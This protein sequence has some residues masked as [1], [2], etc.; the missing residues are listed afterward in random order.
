MARIRIIHWAIVLFILAAGAN[1]QTPASLSST[2]PAPASAP[3]GNADS[4]GGTVAAQPPP[5]AV[6]PSC[7]EPANAATTS[8]PPISVTVNPATIWQP[9]GGEVIVAVV[10]DAALLKG[11]TARAC[12]G[13]SAAGAD[14]FF[15]PENLAHFG[16]AFIRIRP[17]DTLGLVNLGIVVPDLPEA[18]S[19]VITRWLAGA[20]STGLGVVPVADMRLIGY[21]DAGVLFDVV[22]PVGVTS[23][24]FSLL[25]VAISI[26][27]A[28]LVLHQLSADGMSTRSFIPGEKAIPKVLRLAAR[29]MTF[30]WVLHLIQDGN[31][32]AS[33]SAF[34]ILLWS[35]LV[36][37]SAIYVMALSGSLINIT[38]GT[39]ILLGIAGAAGLI[40][41]GAGRS[42]PTDTQRPPGAQRQTD[43]QRPP[44]TQRITDSAQAAQ[45]PVRPSSDRRDAGPRWADL[46]RDDDDM[47][48]V[49]R[50]QMLF[51]TVVSA[52][53]VALQ[54]LNNYV[55]PDIPSGYQVLMGISNGIYVGKKFT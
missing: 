27:A 9:R 28:M 55:I 41:A 54:V 7:S 29:F 49:T 14:K 40:T 39:L 16:E 3:T 24:R 48:E 26:I 6:I 17:S 43:T 18:S 10:A 1:A 33:L 22:R 47:P 2:S 8:S 32:R 20:R 50:L 25:L 34:Q 21:S 5:H 31:G 12:F 38:P 44:D 15:T 53:F 37:A 46:V 51:F 42:G 23:V 35:I 45:V 30:R 4:H 13:W 11:F 52:G 36:A 19:D